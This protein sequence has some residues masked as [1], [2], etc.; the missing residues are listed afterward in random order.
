MPL[1]PTQLENVKKYIKLNEAKITSHSTTVSKMLTGDMWLNG[2]GWVGAKPPNTDTKYGEVMKMIESIFLSR[3][4]ILEVCERHVEAVV[5]TEPQWSITVTRELGMITDDSG[6]ETPEKPTNEEATR[7]KEAQTALTKW[8]K[9]HDVIFA[10]HQALINA[11]SQGRGVL[12]LYIPPQATV[13]EPEKGVPTIPFDTLANNITRLYIEAPS[14]AT[15]GELRTIT[16]A[17]RGAYYKFV[18]EDNFNRLEFQYLENQASNAKTI[19]QIESQN[20]AQ[21]SNFLE[22]SYA[23]GGRLLIYEIK[24]P[25]IISPQ[26][27]QHQK[28]LNKSLVMMSRNQDLGGFVERTIL[29][30]QQPGVWEKDSN[31]NETFKPAALQMGAG[32]TNFIAPY[33]FKDDLGGKTMIPASIAYREPVDPKVFFDTVKGLREGILAEVKQTHA[34][35][36][37]DSTASAVSRIQATNEFAAKLKLSKNQIEKAFEWMLETTLKLAANFTTDPT[38]YDDL[39]ATCTAIINVT[40]PSSSDIDT[41][42]KL[43]EKGL[44]SAETAMLS[45]GKIT[46]AAAEF[47]KLKRESIQN[48]GY[49]NQNVLRDSLTAA[50]QAKMISA[51]AALMIAGESE[52][53]AAEIVA[54]IQAETVALEA[55]V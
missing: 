23:T 15:S 16:N 43:N 49:G 4:V 46:D 44:M 50:V 47:E 52:T 21:D 25:S 31:N 30:G 45:T 8:F 55:G 38:R 17:L 36:A 39:R 32:V 34:L 53:R 48:R 37:G 22:V 24:L 35:I 6:N 26:V 27:V 18:D 29:N 20:K 3:N 33:E 41:V 11:V 9:H 7:I 54:E 2:E 28:A 40:T 5:G 51:K 14:P 10:V 12:R 1:T 19:I 42:I 13:L